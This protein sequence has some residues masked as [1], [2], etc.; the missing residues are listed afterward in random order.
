M[1]LLRTKAFAV[2]EAFSE[3]TLRASMKEYLDQL[4]A[5]KIMREVSKS[6]GVNI[7]LLSS[8]FPILQFFNRA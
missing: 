4:M 1:L 5:S 7:S 3:N 2:S 6:M 8:D